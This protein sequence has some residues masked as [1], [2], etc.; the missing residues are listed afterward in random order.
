MIRACNGSAYLPRL[1][2]L[3]MLMLA[4]ACAKP[5]TYSPEVTIAEIEKEAAI[6]AKFAKED[7]FEKI[8]GEVKVTSK[9][10][11]RVER[12]EA[13]VVPHATALC[14][15]M[16]SQPNPDRACE[17][18]FA[19]SSEAK[20]I[21][22]FA[23]GKRVVMGPT[24]LQFATN[25]THV[26]FVLAHELAH[27]IMQ[28]PQGG[29]KNTTAGM[30]LGTILDAS[31]GGTGGAFGKLGAQVGRLQYSPAFETEADYIGLYILA[32]A[33]YKIEEA[34]DFWRAMS[35]YDPQGIYA[36]STHP[37]NAERFVVMRKTINEI[38]SKQK[39][40]MSLVPEFLPVENDI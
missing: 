16:F 32:R 34:P 40:R 8:E 3:P 13:R 29:A 4:A 38:R 6:Q 28:H 9:M 5:T 21:N 30:I 22:A 25:D 12:I 19:V 18:A 17:F 10:L 7:P 24:M 23:D 36:R 39:L 20:G 15:E 27:N 37:T 26:A 14:Q 2:I 11:A 1:L 31:I 35:Q 33:G